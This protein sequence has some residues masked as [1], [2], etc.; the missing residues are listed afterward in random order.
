MLVLE[1]YSLEEK[2]RAVTAILKEGI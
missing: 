2:I 1:G